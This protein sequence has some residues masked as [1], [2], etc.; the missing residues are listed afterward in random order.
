MNKYSQIIN[1]LT[2][3]AN[4]LD[5]MGKSEMSSNVD[6]MCRRVY[7]QAVK[8]ASM[9]KQANPAAGAAGA[10]A[11]GRAGAGAA[12]AGAAGR[13]GAGGAGTLT[14]EEMAYADMI[15][16]AGAVGDI[17]PGGKPK[18][19]E[20]SRLSEASK[21]ALNHIWETV[22]QLGEPA[23]QE[24]IL[25]NLNTLVNKTNLISDTIKLLGLMPGETDINVGTKS[26]AE[27][28]AE[29]NPFGASRWWAEDPQE[30]LGDSPQAQKKM[31]EILDKSVNDL[32]QSGAMGPRK[33][34][35]V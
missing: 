27:L 22:K 30:T 16:D 28:E 33:W 3:I 24:F 13:A 8:H 26:G 5:D 31:R 4:R 11:A 10:A 19:K 1:S 34:E 12:G 29:L 9:T 14:A 6:I 21:V 2:T 20:V 35:R 23:K 25:D 17:M 15:G 7:R 32:Q 18:Y